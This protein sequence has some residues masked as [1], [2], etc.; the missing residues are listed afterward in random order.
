MT[1][2]IRLRRFWLRLWFT[3]DF[4]HQWGERA[5]PGALRFVWA[6]LEDD[7]TH[8]LESAVAAGD[9]DGR[10]YGIRRTV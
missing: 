3:V 4:L 6:Y 5:T 1:R 9:I 7:F 2:R 8:A 10:R